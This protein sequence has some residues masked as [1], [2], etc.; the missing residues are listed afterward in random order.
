MM[1]ITQFTI[2]QLFCNKMEDIEKYISDQV[3]LTE[4]KS[5]LIWETVYKLITSDTIV[6]LKQ[7]FSI[8]LAYHFTSCLFLE[9]G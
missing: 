1:K 9:L 4:N 3:P 2:Q 8:S 7:H 5:I 6:I